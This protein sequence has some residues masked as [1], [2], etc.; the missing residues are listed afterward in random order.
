[1]PGCLYDAYVQ[2]LRTAY[3][4]CITKLRCVSLPL[5][6][7]LGYRNGTLLENNICRMCRENMVE[8]EINLLLKCPLYDDL[9]EKK[10]LHFNENVHNLSLKDQYCLLPSNT[11]YW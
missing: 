5:A 8:D 3:K 4:Q 2:Y 9:Q 10:L 11:N 7:E 1:M 6:T